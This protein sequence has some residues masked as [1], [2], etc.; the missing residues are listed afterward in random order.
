MNHRVTYEANI[1]EKNSNITI[2]D[3]FALQMNECNE[4]KTKAESLITENG[5][6]PYSKASLVIGGSVLYIFGGAYESHWPSNEIFTVDLSPLVP[7]LSLEQ[8]C[9][10]TISSHKNL[11][12]KEQRDGIPGEIKAQNNLGCLY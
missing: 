5:V 11:Y 6:F 2:T 8:Q 3:H 10:V 1:T 4:S 7:Y 12:T 9:T